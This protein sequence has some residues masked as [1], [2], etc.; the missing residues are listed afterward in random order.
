MSAFISLGGLTASAHVEAAPRPHP[1]LAPLA[2]R[3]QQGVFAWRDLKVG[4]RLLRTLLE[5]APSL[6]RIKEAARQFESISWGGFSPWRGQSRGLDHQRGLTLMWS[7]EGALR[8]LIAHRPGESRS[9]FREA[10]ALINQGFQLD[11]ELS[12]S[13]QPFSRAPATSASHEPSIPPIPHQAPEALARQDAARHSSEREASGVARYTQRTPRL[14]CYERAEPQ[15]WLICDTPDVQS[16]PAPYWLTA[17]LDRGAMWLFTHA[18]AEVPSPFVLPWE[19]V[20]LHA[21]LSGDELR[22]STNLNAGFNPLLEMFRPTSD[23]SEVTSWIHADAPLAF[24]ISLDPE[25]VKHAGVL[26]AQ[27]AWL[28]QAQQLIGAGWSGEA[29]LTFDG[30]FDHPV[31]AL[32]LS[33]HPWSADK[34]SAVLCELIGAHPLSDETDASGIRWW[35]I[36]SSDGLS[37]GGLVGARAQA[38]TSGWRIPVMAAEQSLIIGLFP[39]DVKRRAS[40]RFRPHEAPISL[41]LEKRGISGGFIDP[42]M[43]EAR[44]FD[45]GRISL[46]TLAAVWSRLVEEGGDGLVDVPPPLASES[47]SLAGALTRLAR[48]ES[49]HLAELLEIVSDA[50]HQDEALFFAAS[51]LA[52][53]TLQLIET[54]K[55]TAYSYTQAQS[56]SVGITFEITVGIL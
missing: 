33:P 2:I 3:G 17:D 39:A 5:R 46:S 24:K 40:T 41:E 4:R 19:S 42:L 47:S 44:G 34:L 54:L 49:S 8:L 30:G 53:L 1:H 12:L 29:L 21:D 36:D 55:W 51:D 25:V 50:L 27:R 28:S 48:F 38:R 45:G 26:S 6:P 16:G 11:W 14:I 22:L 7:R 37:R 10:R 9:A 32:S 18:P 56:G 35:S 31:L 23:L 13:S 43:F 52:S 15:G 20:E